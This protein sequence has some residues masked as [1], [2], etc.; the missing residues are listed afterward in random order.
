M[1]M[2]VLICIEEN[3]VKKLVGTIYLPSVFEIKASGPVYTIIMMMD[4]QGGGGGRGGGGGGGRCLPH[5]LCMRT[6]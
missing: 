5:Y 2:F 1:C 4:T 3:V 6:K